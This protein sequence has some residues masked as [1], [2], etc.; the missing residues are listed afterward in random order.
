M[1]VK[2]LCFAFSLCCV[3]ALVLA[4]EPNDGANIAELSIEDL[5]AL[6]IT[7]DDAFDIFGALVSTQ[8][9]SVASGKQQDAFRAPAVT[10]VITVQD[11]EAMGARTLNE[12]LQSVPGLY[13]GKDHSYQPIY[14]M[15]GINSAGSPHILLLV[16]GIP[17]KRVTDGNRGL[18]WRDMPVSNIQRIEVIRGP[19]SAMYGADAFSGTVNIITK[20]AQDIN[21]TQA[22]SRFD[23][24]NTREGWVLHGQKYGDMEVAA[25]LNFMD[26]DGSESRVQRDMQ[27]TIDEALGT[28]A[29]L[30]PGD[31]RT[32][33]RTLNAQLDLSQN[34]WRGRFAYLGQ[35][36]DSVMG[37]GGSLED[38]GGY[39][40]EYFTVDLLY[41]NP[42]LSRNWSVT[43]QFNYA[44]DTIDSR[45]GMT[46]ANISIPYFDGTQM[47]FF[48]LPEGLRGEYSSTEQRIHLGGTAFYAGFDKHLLRFG[49]GLRSER[50][51]DTQVSGYIGINT[52]GSLIPLDYS[53]LM[54]DGQVISPTLHRKSYYGFIQDTWYLSS[55]WEFT[56]GVRYDHYSD[57]G[58]TTNPRAAL[59]WQITPSLTTK[60][61]YGTA[62]RAPS[63]GDAYLAY[64]PITQTLPT[65]KPET[66]ATTELAFN[67][68][69]SDKLNLGFN[70]YSY[71]VKDLIQSVSIS[72]VLMA[73]NTGKIDGNGFEFEARW[74]LNART[75][76]L[77]NYAWMDTQYD[78]TELLDIPFVSTQGLPQQMA[79]VRMDRL[80]T[81]NWYL[82]AQLNWI[83]KQKRI[84]ASDTRS[85]IA[86][87]FNLGLTLRYKDVHN[88]RWNF[89]VGIRNLLDEEIVSQ[90]ISLKLPEGIPQAGRHVFAEVQYRFD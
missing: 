83:G 82:D 46:A 20:T 36:A 35:D 32:G 11:I 51:I 34:N 75:S 85:P 89:A 58:G 23:S 72:D 76:L 37:A 57:F 67:W 19:G 17:F 43:G 55:D 59:V 7:L 10:S 33:E 56:W 62:F 5:L 31:L 69:A 1:S 74:K 12:A 45:F 63:F 38:W 80:L 18:G 78:N 70:I 22:G 13:I 66:N 77:F 2:S 49:A 88:P 9:V 68:R 14:A 42:V 6:E 81:K 44:H 86:D 28:R 61:L 21:G 25:S 73:M 29:S 90:S 48:T 50:P 40:R 60:L 8:Q 27:S 39:Q 79:Y 87:T 26:T 30:A 16:N 4:N 52:D 53:T 64:N 65:L 24:F 71:Q 54:I 84:S 41:D 3:P 47:S 15:R